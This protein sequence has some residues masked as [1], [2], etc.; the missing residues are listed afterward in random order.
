VEFVQVAQ[1]AQDLDRAADFYARLLGEPALARFDPPGLVF[2]GVRGVRLLLDR[3]APSAL[4]YLHVGDVRARVEALRG[5][6][7]EVVGEPNVIFVHADDTLGPAGTAEVQAF[8]RDSEGN[9]VGLVG[10][11]TP[12]PPRDPRDDE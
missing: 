3:E 5:E 1:R 4:L 7:V 9:T 12:Q 11:E 2:F 6:G 10:F 8:V